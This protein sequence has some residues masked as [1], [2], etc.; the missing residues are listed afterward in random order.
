M[1][2]H[3]CSIIIPYYNVPVY[4]VNKCLNSILNQDW[5]NESYEV[6]FVN[7][8]SSL[9]LNDSTKEIFKKFPSF[10]LIEQNNAGL[11]A[12]RNAGIKIAKGDY[13]L[14]IDPDDYWID[15]KIQELIPFLKEKEHD[16][17]KF[18][19]IHV[20]EG[21]P[22]VVPSLYSI[23]TIEYNS[24]CDYMTQSNLIK[25][26]CTYCFKRDFIITNN[27]YMPE[28]LI[29]EDEWF[30]TTA[31]FY[32]KK[33]LF[34]NIPLYAYIKRRGSITSRKTTEQWNRSFSHFFES[35]KMAT[36]LKS[37][38]GIATLQITGIENRLSYLIYDYFYNII[39]S[40]LQPKEKETHL[41]KLRNIN[42][43]PLPQIGQNPKYN[44]LR[45]LSNNKFMLNFFFKSIHIINNKRVKGKRY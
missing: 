36:T 10:T 38:N 25:G 24:G 27:I 17:I 6:I 37:Q 2:K 16:I 43:L 8:G 4:L 9:P 22:I 11:S 7:D 28:G 39:N 26:A 40:P 31:F 3:I 18:Q 34:T 1:N 45:S 15:N 44:I 13:I 20:Y 12:A 19:T 42:L 21:T 41:N 35:L 14:F 32:A 33:C 30:L 5:E 29:H 23:S